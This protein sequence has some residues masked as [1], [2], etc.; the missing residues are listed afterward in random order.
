M[1][2]YRARAGLE[3]GSL[4]V[5]GIASAKVHADRMTQLSH[6]PAEVVILDP[7]VAPW[8]EPPAHWVS[9]TKRTILLDG[10]PAESDG[11][12][13]LSIW[14]VGSFSGPREPS[15][16]LMALQPDLRRL[17]RQ[18]VRA[19][20]M[21]RLA[22]A[23]RALPDP[24]SVW[25]DAPG[26]E[27]E[28]VTLL[29]SSQLAP[30]L[31]SL[32]VRVGVVAC[33]EGAADAAALTSSLEKAGFR[34]ADTGLGDPNV[35]DLRFVPEQG[36][37][38]G[39]QVNP[40]LADAAIPYRTGLEQ[41]I[42]G[43]AE[44]V[45]RLRFERAALS[46]E[47]S[48]QQTYIQHLL[49]EITVTPCAVAVATHSQAD[50]EVSATELVPEELPL[51]R[52]RDGDATPS[53]SEQWVEPASADAVLRIHRKPGLI[54][55]N[56]DWQFPA[57]TEK[58]AFSRLTSAFVTLPDNALFVAYPWATLIDK[59]EGSAPDADAHLQKFRDFCN[60]LEGRVRR[61]TVCQHIHGRKYEHLFQDAGISDVFWSHTTKADAAAATSDGGA[62]RYHPFPL[63]P[64]QIPEVLPEADVEADSQV[65][66]HLYCFVGARSDHYYLSK[67][68][69]WIVDLL[70]E[71][72]RGLVLGREA[73]HYKG[74]VY[75]LQIQG[76]AS[77]ADAASLIDEEASRQFCEAMRDSTFALCPSGSGPNTIRVWEALAAGAIP[78]I[79]SDSWAP[80]GDPKLWERAAVFSAETPEAIHGLPAR[81]EGIASDR[82]RLRDMRQAM[83]QIWSRYGPDA[84]VSDILALMLREKT[85]RV[86]KLAGGALS[87]TNAPAARPG[88]EAQPK[89]LEHLLLTWGGHLL[90]DPL[91]AVAALESGQAVTAQLAEARKQDTRGTLRAHFDSAL[92]FALQRAGRAL[93]A[94]Q[95]DI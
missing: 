18:T 2:R 77:P 81:L 59:L 78:V 73:W 61:F 10:V 52:A 80:P 72:P 46:D 33:F 85:G 70:K 38:I 92:A 62:I 65:R 17:R 51:D 82:A 87:G 56:A 48:R 40:G 90:V 95:G 26:L 39:T 47:L 49:A 71:D 79:L 86:P 83:R 44:Q 45:E 22:E 7:M 66:R 74:M 35:P 14:S 76:V 89:T 43:M 29:Q 15:A 12:V 69:N 84:F 55:M 3:Q 68:R 1:A 67:A 94:L 6:R 30:R 63:Y 34:L 27:A 32:T 25:I 31:Q 54:G 75:D 60:Y 24:L 91:G 23:L 57:I 19:R 8:S 88:I 11:E 28:I 21:A 53:A 13:V 58:H 41:Q 16:A 93:P 37:S 20:A 42:W 50:N 4:I 5:F 9:G 36:S 64:V